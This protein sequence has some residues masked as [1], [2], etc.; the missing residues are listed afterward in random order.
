M[1]AMH[2]ELKVETLS[3]VNLMQAA[4]GNPS[5]KTKSIVCPDCE[6]NGKCKNVDFK[7][8]RFMVFFLIFLYTWV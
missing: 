1:L 4:D 2:L 5:T 6:G 3:D 7:Y 8:F